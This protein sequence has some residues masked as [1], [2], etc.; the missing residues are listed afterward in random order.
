MMEGWGGYQTVKHMRG[1]E[2]M[3]DEGRFGV[4]VVLG[5]L[6]LGDGW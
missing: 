4:T 5:W 1:M 2:I 6:D 3:G